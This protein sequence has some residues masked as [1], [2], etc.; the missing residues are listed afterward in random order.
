MTSIR[1]GGDTT[2]EPF[3]I[4]AAAAWADAEADLRERT[5]RTPRTA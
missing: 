2:A 5:T 4:G 3:G 1:T